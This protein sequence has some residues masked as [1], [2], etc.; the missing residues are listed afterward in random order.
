LKS[1]LSLTRPRIFLRSVTNAKNYNLYRIDRHPERKGGTAIAVR[2]GTP[3]DKWICLLVSI[4]TTGLCIPIGNC[5][6]LLSAVYKSPNR[7][8]C[9][10]D[11]IELLMFLNECILAGDL[12]AKHPFWNSTLSNPSDEKVCNCSL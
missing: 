3:T 6:V 1:K 8:W 2:K 9:D 7:T 4:E 12:N 11:I 10:T 5:E